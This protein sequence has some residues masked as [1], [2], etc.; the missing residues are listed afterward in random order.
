MA[1]ERTVV[2]PP[3]NFDSTFEKYRGSIPLEYLRALAI[4]SGGGEFKPN[5]SSSDAAG[6]FMIS[7][8]ALAAYGT[9]VGRTYR[10]TDLADIQLSTQVVV[11]LINNVK[12]YFSLNYPK[13]LG[14]NWEKP[15]Y[16]AVVTLGFKVGHS[17]NGGVGDAAKII[18]SLY[19][20]KMSVDSIAEVA[21]LKGHASYIYSPKWTSFAKDVANLYAGSPRNVD[22]VNPSFP[23]DGVQ[24]AATGRGLGIAGIAV[25]AAIPI[26]ALVFS[27]KKR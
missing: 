21:K 25:I 7:P 1:T 13:S 27:G 2:T 22:S 20:E 4:V 19:P 24:V 10:P 18:E 5:N 17:E 6:L 14:E 3:R 16:V 23:G 11:W 26:L 15:N 12:N 9:S 8:G